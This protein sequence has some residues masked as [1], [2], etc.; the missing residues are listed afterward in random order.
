VYTE[1][2]RLGIL[3][4]GYSASTVFCDLSASARFF[5][6]LVSFAGCFF[7]QHYKLTYGKFLVMCRHLQALKWPA[8]RGA[9]EPEH[10]AGNADVQR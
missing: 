8:A 4:V 9:V 10:E 5:F 6:C 2:I 1:G 3:I 7:F